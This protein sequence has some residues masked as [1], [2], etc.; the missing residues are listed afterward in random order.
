MTKQGEVFTC[1]KPYGPEFNPWNSHGGE[2]Y[3]CKLLL[4]LHNVP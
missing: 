4:D 3:S 2:T 1:V